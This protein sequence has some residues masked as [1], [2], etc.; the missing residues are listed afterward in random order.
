MITQGVRVDIIQLS[1]LSLPLILL[2]PLLAN[3][4]TWRFWR[5]LSAFWI[6]LS[7]ALLALL[8]VSRPRLSRSTIR[9]LTVCLSSNGRPRP[10]CS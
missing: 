4:P 1:L 7:I 3:G 9:A 5:R 6:V 2:A 8:E 10:K